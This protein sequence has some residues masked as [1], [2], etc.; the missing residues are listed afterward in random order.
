MKALAT[1]TFVLDVRI[2]KLKAFIETLFDIIQFGAIEI[3]KA[4]RIDHQLNIATVKN[5]IFRLA[6]RFTKSMAGSGRE[7]FSRWVRTHA[8]PC[9]LYGRPPV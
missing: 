9:W 4:F 2:F 1:A 8:P 7:S 3:E 6:I 5:F